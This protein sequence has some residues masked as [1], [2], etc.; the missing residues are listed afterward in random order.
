MYTHSTDELSHDRD[1]GQ[2]SG[3]SQHTVHSNERNVEANRE[4]A[5]SRPAHQ[6]KYTREDSSLSNQMAAS[7]S[8]TAGQE[9][10][11]QHSMDKGLLDTPSGQRTESKNLLHDSDA[12][13][14]PAGTT[15]AATH[16]TD[17]NHLLHRLNKL[18]DFPS[19]GR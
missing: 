9:I 5:D 15:T 8:A 6:E 12:T 7:S 11:H 4:H 2:E 13:L 17:H 18:E 19:G 16:M 3:G 1:G 10:K 14:T